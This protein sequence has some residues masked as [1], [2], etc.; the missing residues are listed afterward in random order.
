MDPIF[1]LLS[2]ITLAGGVAAISLRRLVHCALSLAV[3]LTGVA[4]LY[5]QLG[6]QFVGFAQVLVYV[7]A[8]A[9]LIVFAILLTRGGDE[10]RAARGIGGWIAGLV[11][12]VLAGGG[13]ALSVLA[14]PAL[15]RIAPAPAELSLKQLGTELM[16]A[17]V[18]P[19]EVLGVLLTAAT[20]GAVLMAMKD[21][22]AA[23]QDRAQPG[24][25]ARGRSGDGHPGSASN[26]APGG[27]GGA[28]ATQ[29]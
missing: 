14:S 10:E 1:I 7:G 25:G 13:V 26:V 16:G 21:P 11:A 29:P 12:A 19:L 15:R 22:P 23:A 5:L 6:A 4:L 9:I 24:A 8:V 20:I 3:C 18:V 17:Y 27:A 2:A 28:A